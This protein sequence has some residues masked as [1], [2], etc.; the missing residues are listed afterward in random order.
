MKR[1]RK[2]PYGQPHVP[3]D[4][5]RARGGTRSET[6]L[7]GATYTVRTVTSDEKTY[8][9]PGCHQSIPRGASHVVAWTQEDIF[10]P[11]AG[12]ESR[13]HWHSTC[14]DIAKRRGW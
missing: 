8:T 3:L 10:G 14:W 2:R 13:R 11:A 1:S 9:C 12:L 7:G 4:I 5:T 6:A